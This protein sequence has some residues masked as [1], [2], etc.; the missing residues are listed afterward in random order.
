MKRPEAEIVLKNVIKELDQNH[1]ELAEL[2]HQYNKIKHKAKL[3]FIVHKTKQLEQKIAILDR[4]YD[5][6]INRLA[7]M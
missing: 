1:Q 6:A 4:Q 5:R 3:R 7:I 2:K